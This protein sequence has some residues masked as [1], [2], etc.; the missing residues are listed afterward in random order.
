MRRAIALVFAVGFALAGPRL[1]MP[2]ERAAGTPFVYEPPPGFIAQHKGLETG[3]SG[4]DEK[5]W[6]IPQMAPQG[7]VPR[8]TTAHVAQK[9][10]VEAED[11]AKTV[12]GLPQTFSES[13]V[14]WTLKRSETRERKDGARVGVVLGDCMPSKAGTPA[15]ARFQALQLLFP[16]DTG[17]T[18][19]KAYVSEADAPNVLPLVEQTIESARGVAMRLPPPPSWAYAAF[20]AAGALLGWG[21]G[22]VIS[23]VIERRRRPAGA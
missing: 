9:S 1:T 11:L 12:G 18:V 3:A 7:M 19:V 22:V 10:T 13:G 23:V 15:T 20:G 2:H 21:V 8:I 5:T 4:G 17:T 6:V 16:D 14:T